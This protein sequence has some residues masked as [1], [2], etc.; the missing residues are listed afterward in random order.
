MDG[1]N[2]LNDGIFVAGIRFDDHLDK[3]GAVG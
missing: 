3:S 1:L 2:H